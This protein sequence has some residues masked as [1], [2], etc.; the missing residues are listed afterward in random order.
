M[1]TVDLLT[2]ELSRPNGIAF[3]K[4]EKKLYVANSDT[5]KIWMVYDVKAD[6]G[7]KTEKY[8][9]MLL[10]LKTPDHRMA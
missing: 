7:L 8:F 3:S 10:P 1:K 5:N 4:D 6:G 9:M 2:K